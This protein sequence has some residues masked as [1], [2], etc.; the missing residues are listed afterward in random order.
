MCYVSREIHTIQCCCIVVTTFRCHYD[1][2]YSKMLVT[3]IASE[4]AT[5]EV[6]TSGQSHVDMSTPSWSTLHGMLLYT[7]LLNVVYREPVTCGSRTGSRY[8]CLLGCGL[9][10]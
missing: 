1:S 3:P 10:A 6:P 7:V 4:M 9:G 2:P 5:S 8:D